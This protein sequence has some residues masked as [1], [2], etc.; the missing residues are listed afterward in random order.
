MS[1]RIRALGILESLAQYPAGLKSRDI[2]ALLKMPPAAAER[3]VQG[4][5]ESGFAFRA[6]DGSV[7]LSVKLAALGL[8]Y[9]G[10]SGITDLV[11]PI[12]DDLAKR[13]GELVRLAVVESDHLTWVAKS[14][15]AQSGLFYVPHSEPE[16]YLAA[17]AN[18]QAWL[19]SLD[20]AHVRMLVEKQGLHRPD[21]GPNAPATLD[22]LRE[23]VEET[24][25]LGYARVTEAYE[26]GT[27]AMAVAIRK[28]SVGRPVG[29]ISVAGPTIRMTQERM[30]EIAPWLQASANELGA[31]A[32]SSPLFSLN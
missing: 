15:S 18:G 21:L 12:L 30:A 20:D 32:A 4:L 8:A 25:K 10:T 31:A 19:A 16:V 26:V 13:T 22:E 29:T 5:I 17:T 3:T 7:R 2:A 11:Q 27:S 6:A 28:R 24:R 9:L 23:Q 14:Q 1:S